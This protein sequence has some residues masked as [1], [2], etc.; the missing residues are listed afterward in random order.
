LDKEN[1]KKYSKNKKNKFFN[2]NFKRRDDYINF[3]SDEER[4][5]KSIK[6]LN[7]D[8]IKNNKNSNKF[9]FDNDT[10]KRDYFNKNFQIDNSLSDCLS[11]FSNE[12]ISIQKKNQPPLFYNNLHDNKSEEKRNIHYDFNKKKNQILEKG[13]QIKRKKE[14]LSMN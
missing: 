4:V 1:E 12:N 3:N 11:I 9:T 14:Y 5:I 2:Q 8:V 10:E 7:Q 6:L 13:K